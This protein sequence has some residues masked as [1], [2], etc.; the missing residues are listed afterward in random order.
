MKKA[1][2][3]TAILVVVALVFLFDLSSKSAAR[4]VIPFHCNEGIALGFGFLGRFSIPVAV[5]ALLLLSIYVF[6]L[7]KKGYFGYALALS[8][9]IGGGAANLIDRVFNGCVTDFIPFFGLWT[10]N[11]ADIFISGAAAVF[12][13]LLLIERNRK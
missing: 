7:Q 1:S 10:M 8:V 9:I 13:L 5:L 3:S 11:V 2:E 4:S 12:V 6:Y